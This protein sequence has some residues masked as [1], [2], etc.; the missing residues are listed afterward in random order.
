[1]LPTPTAR[2]T[3]DDGVR[4]LRARR[5]REALAVLSAVLAAEPDRPDV[6][7]AAALGLVEVG[8]LAQAV[9]AARKVVALAPAW[10]TGWSEL[11]WLLS[12]RGVRDEPA[13]CWRRALSLDPDHRESRV[14]LAVTLVSEGQLGAAEEHLHLARRR[15]PDDPGV[16]AAAITWLERKGRDEEAWAVGARASSVDPRVAIALA[17]V[18][19]RT[20]RAASSLGRVDAALAAAPA[21]DRPLLLHARAELLDALDRPDEAFAA[22]S[23]ANAERR[24]AFDPVGFARSIDARIAATRAGP[25][26]AP[27]PG[28]ERVVLIVGVP[29]TGSTLLETALSRHPEV[30]AGGELHLLADTAA[31]AARLASTPDALGPAERGALAA[32]YLAGLADLDPSASRV[33]DKM[34]DNLLHLHWLAAI[35]P[36]A[37][38]LRCRRDARDTAWSCFRQPFGAGLPWATSL[39]GIAAYVAGAERLLDHFAATLPLRFHDVRYEELVTHPEEVLRGVCAFLDLPFVPEVLHPEDADRT[40][41]TASVLEVKAPMH[42]G[43]VGRG[44]RYARHLDPWFPPAQFG[45]SGT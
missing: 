4:L 37:R 26:P 43:S 28:A 6:W 27:A 29:R 13:A 38:V 16:Q 25:A 35:L 31:S 40:A 11:G 32:R 5:P 41:A 23:A 19:R 33:T 2:P 39:P 9:T 44:A 17:S 10:P 22:W 8:D 7:L 34:P 3:L 36:G 21:V 24:L 45:G 12:L 1:M 20:G 14:R 30:A 15:W 42:A 18:G